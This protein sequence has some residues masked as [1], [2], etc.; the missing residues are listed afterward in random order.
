[1]TYSWIKMAK[2]PS[3]FSSNVLLLSVVLLLPVRGAEKTSTRHADA[4]VTFFES[5]H[6]GNDFIHLTVNTETQTVYVGAVNY[7]YSLQPNLS[8]WQTV[9][10]GPKPDSPDCP[11]PILNFNDC[12]YPKKETKSYNKVLVV[13]YTHQRLI[14]C[15]SLFQGFCEK[16]HLDDITKVDPS[17]YKPVAA[18]S[19]NA[20]T[21]AFIAPGPAPRP[22]QVQNNVLYVSVSWNPVGQAIWREDVPAFSSRNLSNFELAYSD[23]FRQT[24]IKIEIQQRET[25]LVT[26]LYGFGSENFS[27]MITMQKRSARSNQYVSKIFRV[28]QNDPFFYSYVELELQCLSQ[29]EDY[30]L[31]QAAYLGKPGK[32]L[33]QSLTIPTTEDVLYAVFSKGRKSSPVPTGKSALC[34]YPMRL[35]RRVFTKN[36]QKCFSGIGNTGP[37]H[38]STP[39][40]CLKST[41]TSITDD[42]CGD[43]INQPIG[44]SDPIKSEAALLFPLNTHPTAIA[45]S[46]TEEYT[47]AF[48]GTANGSLVKVSLESM[49]EAS[50]YETV[51]VQTQQAV[52]KD[53]HFDEEHDHLYV[54][55][56]NRVS[57]VRVQDC[58]QYTTCSECLGARDP[59]CG[60]C[61]LE[62]KCSLKSECQGSDIPKRW[63]PYQGEECTKI[64]LVLPNQIQKDQDQLLTLH[65]QN[66]PDFEKHYTYH[67]AFT[68]LGGGPGGSSGIR[69]LNPPDLRTTANRTSKGIQCYSPAPHL[70]PPIPTDF[71]LMKLS[72]VM[73]Q[74]EFVST[75]F[76]FFDC[77]VHTSCTSCT[78]SLFP[79]TWCIM[80][81]QCTDQSEVVCRRDDVLITGKSVT[82]ISQTPGPQHCPRI[83]VASADTQILVPADTTR[84]IDVHGVAMQDFQNDLRCEFNIDTGKTVPAKVKPVH[85]NK[86]L[87]E[88]SPL[89]FNYHRN[90][91]LYSVPFKVY[92]GA[93]S[94]PLDN[95]DGVQVVMYKCSAMAGSC[96]E[97]FTVDSKYHC[98]W[99]GN[100]KCSTEKFCS[101]TWL[102]PATVCPNPT[103]TLIH[104]DS[105]PSKGGTRLTV[106][107]K[108]LGIQED[109]VK[110]DVDGVECVVQEFVAPKKIVCVTG[111]ASMQ[112]QKG[113]VRVIVGNTHSGI[114]SKEFHYVEPEIMDIIPSSGPMDGGTR[115]TIVGNHM[116]AGTSISVMIGTD[117]PCLNVT[118]LSEKNLTCITTNGTESMA[119]R[120]R[121]N[122][123]FDRTW[124]RSPSYITFTY[125]HNPTI[126]GVDHKE[127]IIS[128]GLK[129]MAI[130]EHLDRIQSPQMILWYN[131]KAYENMC[132]RSRDGKHMVCLTPPVPIPGEEL[133]DKSQ[134]L[135]YGFRLD[136]V[137]SLRNLTDLSYEDHR[138]MEVFP[139]PQFLHFEGGQKVHQQ[140]NE[141]LVIEGTRLGPLR[142]HDVAITIGQDNCTEV[143][144]AATIVTCKPPSSQPHSVVGGELPEVL[145]TVGNLTFPV[146]VLR[147]EEPEVLSFPAIIAIAVG[148]SV[149]LIVLVIVCILYRVKSRRN[150]DM[151]KKMRI[152]MDMLEA[153]VAN[154]CKEAFAELQTD[155]TELTSDTYGQVTIPFWDYRS[156]C[157]R[158]MFP[159]SEDHPVIRDLQY[160]GDS[161]ERGLRQF[162]GLIS[163]KTFVLTFIRT[164][165]ANKNFHLR[166]RVNV[167]SL[168]SV[169]L[170]TQMEYSTE[171][172]KTLLAELIEKTVE[173]KNT[174]KLLL[175]RN[176]SVA[177]KML[178]NWFT[179]LL[180]KFLKECAGEPLFMLFQAI[181]QQ[182]SKGPVD[183]ITGEAR[184]SLS[185]DKLIRQQIQYKSLTLYVLDVDVD[186]CTQPAHPVKVLDCD[187]ISQV[188][189][190]ILDAIY[191]NAPFSSRPPKDELDLVLFDHPPDWVCADK[192]QVPPRTFPSRGD[193]NRLVLHDE[194]STSKVEGDCKHINTLAHYQVPDGAYVALHPKQL[195]PTYNISI[196]SEKSNLSSFYN[197]SPSLT[198]SVTPQM[199]HVAV[200]VDNN[201]IKHFHLVRQHDVEP[202]K[203][204]DRGSKMVSEIYL[205]RLLVTK[206]TLQQF[207]DDLFERI[208]STAHRGSA[209]PLAIKYMFDFLD[210]QA[211]LHNIQDPE[212]VHT[213]KSN[214]L[215]LRF[216]VNVIKNPDFAFDVHKTS[217]AD[218]CLTVVGQTFM[219]ACSQSEHRLGKDSPSSKLLYAKDIPKYK[220]WV[221]RYYQDIK[222]IPAISDQDMTAMLTEESRIHNS[223]FN[224]NAA[225]L[226]LYKYAKKYNEELMTALEEDEFARKSKLN[227][228]LDQVH[229]AM[230]GSANC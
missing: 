85:D 219:D 158:I 160:C 14:A 40:R 82:G 122:I 127:S 74:Q 221:E 71:I 114:S 57:K 54:M 20:S 198:R 128:G 189:E 46:I 119:Q 178:T 53:M 218:S 90:V 175:R 2:L 142:N 199:I 33:A 86:V 186:R 166:D 129:I 42:Y 49:S 94:H 60:W 73:N 62:N 5:P 41:Q 162:A 225:L 97:C 115:V 24:R 34:I 38:L 152:Q 26:Y 230:D 200:D 212:V 69:S 91:S 45:V 211:L 15:S 146:G 112:S 76:T 84:P 55:T 56:D 139:D 19:E 188:K 207:V 10:T 47:V 181:K 184:Y 155:M 217:I 133:K 79:C 8:H 195:L 63:L 224:T 143:N 83:E 226:E 16:R 183:S 132:E 208:F 68:S 92:W 81:H 4:V 154:E 124:V 37:D 25:F 32:V 66:L 203:E 197:R 59:Y 125:L 159:G 185:E 12:S 105:G 103:I 9:K 173:S 1:M 138:M 23:N 223:E 106:I 214:S 228:K 51:M 194:D 7:L 172:L 107:G 190:K 167:A 151:M 140:K 170:Q 126:K 52:N 18:N 113:H 179:F 67:C 164:L 44:G 137:Q 180:Y 102:S 96:G 80:S 58:K 130:G 156:Y 192:S 206:G 165:E 72:V 22:G 176:E 75:N 3:T 109:D 163:N 161:V 64:T 150:D 144:V 93:G 136:G 145:V 147:Y 31:L 35:V 182:T 209:L 36:I 27:Y 43:E 135:S 215:P 98:G 118:S 70:L 30:N 153:R 202:S 205:P 111:A 174:P 88:C 193:T 6:P 78:E 99:C 169:A 141:L 222:M 101:A 28:C 171:I 148:A 11:P 123:T 196:M 48:V 213:W 121:I 117:M 104:P 149:L 29:G 21:V 39:V 120:H 110:V 95:P 17:S 191:K 65:I 61:T 201:G 216:W 220:Q 134:A 204:G 131:K 116:D 87:I 157:M 100:L 50:I 227:Y 77:N 210:D 229:A 108:N 89:T 177:E 168:I 13:D 187:T